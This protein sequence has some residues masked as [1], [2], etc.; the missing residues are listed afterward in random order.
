M[1]QDVFIFA[2]KTSVKYGRGVIPECFNQ[3]SGGGH[4]FPTHRFLLKD[5]R[6]DTPPESE[7]LLLQASNIIMKPKLDR[8]TG[9][10]G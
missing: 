7:V 2:G 9:F 3:E 4:Y 6:N 5:C 10:S 8:I 1:N